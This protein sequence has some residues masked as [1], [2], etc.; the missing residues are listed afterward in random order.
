MSSWIWTG[1]EIRFCLNYCENKA[2]LVSPISVIRDG[3]IA[4][5]GSCVGDN[6]ETTSTDSGPGHS[7][8]EPS[9]HRG[10]IVIVDL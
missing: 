5:T 6:S 1:P 7:N 2:T 10:Y 9:T 8:R 3:Y 4:T